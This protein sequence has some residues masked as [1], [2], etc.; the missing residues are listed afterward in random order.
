MKKF[1]WLLFLLVISVLI[2][3]FFFRS[4][5]KD[6]NFD[7]YQIKKQDLI[8]TLEIDGLTEVK[9][10]AL[11]RFALGGKITSLN[12]KEGD[13]VGKGQVLATIDQKELQKRLEKSLNFYEQT[14]LD[15][16]QQLDDIKD[17]TIDK[18]ELRQVEKNQITLDNSVID[19]E[20]VDIS[21]QENIL[22]APFAGVIIQAPPLAKEVYWSASDGFEIVSLESLYFKALVDE[23]DLASVYLNQKGWLEIDA[24]ENEKISTFVNF[25]AYKGVENQSGTIFVADLFFPQQNNLNKYRLNMKGQAHLI[26]DEKKDILAVPLEALEKKDDFYYLKIYQKDNHKVPFKEIKID[27]G[28]ENDEMVEIISSE[29]QEGDQI[30]LSN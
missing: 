18:K 3:F 1:K 29:I 12:V 26:L 22:K 15:W 21:I 11:V 10:K 9:K 25:L 14:R 4:Q 8:K 28:L 23:V 24:Y 2:W 16:D 20:L 5:K 17:R 27:L 30:I 7:L 19:V 13:W 6:L